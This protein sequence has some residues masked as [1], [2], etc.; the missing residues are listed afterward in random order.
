MSALLVNAKVDI[1]YNLNTITINV[2][3]T[4]LVKSLDKNTIPTKVTLIVL[5]I[6]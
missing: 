6:Y 4:V 3:D 2:Y 5:L 1:C